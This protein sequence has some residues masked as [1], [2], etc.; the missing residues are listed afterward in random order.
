MYH[1]KQ[2]CWITVTSHLDCTVVRRCRHIDVI[3]RET[4]VIYWLKVAKH[5]VLGGWLVEVPQLQTQDKEWVQKGWI[6]FSNLDHY[7][8]ILHYTLTFINLSLEQVTSRR[9]RIVLVNWQWLTCSSC[10]SS[11]A[12]RSMAR[13]AF[14]TWGTRENSAC[15]YLVG[16]GLFCCGAGVFLPW[17]FCHWSRLQADGHQ[18]RRRS[19][20]PRRHVPG[21][22]SA[23]HLWCF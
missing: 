5:G 16:T 2:S 21:S 11:K 17:P 6:I 7:T 19:R 10:S 1:H 8:T 3:W 9:R 23:S 15:L 20:A 4:A 14:Q 22:L 13:S 12:L 18:G